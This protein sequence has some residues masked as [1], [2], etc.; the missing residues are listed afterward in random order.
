MKDIQAD[1]IQNEF[2][3]DYGNRQLYINKLSLRLIFQNTNYFRHKVKESALI[4]KC[5]DRN[6]YNQSLAV[7]THREL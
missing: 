1:E 2:L 5:Q 7:Y 6:A 3:T 4:N